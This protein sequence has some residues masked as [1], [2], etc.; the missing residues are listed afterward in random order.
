MSGLYARR[1]FQPKHLLLVVNHS[2]GFVPRNLLVRASNLTLEN[3]PEAS[4]GYLG[5]IRFYVQSTEHSA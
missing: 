4:L 3:D 2:G 5:N 1:G